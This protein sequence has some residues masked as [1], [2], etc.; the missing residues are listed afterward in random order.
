MTLLAGCHNIEDLRAVAR[1]KLPAPMFHYIDG[2][3]DDETTLRR[4]TAAF[5]DVALVP[6]YLVDVG[7][8][9][10]TTRVM[11]ADVSLPLML[12]P[13]GMSRL[14][15]RD[16]ELAVAAAAAEA[17]V[18]YAL[19]TVATQS[20][21]AVA[22]VN[23][24]PKLFQLYILRD[25]G[26]N[27]EFIAR[28][29]DAGYQGLCLT[30]DVP[31]AGNRERDL[32][33]GMSLP[34]RFGVRGIAELLAKPGWLWG[35]LT[36][37]RL[38]LANVADRAGLAGGATTLARYINSQFDRTVTWEDAAQM[39]AQWG[40]PFAIKGILS[41]E[42]AIRAADAGATA[43]IVSNHGGRQLDGAPGTLDCLREVVDAVGD[44]VEVILDG[45]IRRGT[46]VLKALALGARACMVGRPYL[47]GL[48]AGG[49]PGV[50]RALDLLRAEIERDLALLGCRRV[51][52][53]H[54]GH[55]RRLV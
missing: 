29:R 20:I 13:T 52:E 28:C 35:H 6:R 21:E 17:G 39:I 34:P 27:A 19:S 10:T 18:F 54:A 50:G 45:G 16:G 47:Y 46:H 14:F 49:A 48:A 1:R 8:I 11:G 26:L 36:S 33:T 2:A 53:V 40:G 30:V 4:N 22:G 44:R 5:D 25:R 24:G 7:E 32:R 38:E 37:P 12:A 23:S 31:I 51:D 3:A 42:D 43:V 9:D 41:G 55:V 15:H